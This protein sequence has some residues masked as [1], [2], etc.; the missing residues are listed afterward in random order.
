MASSNMRNMPP[1][2]N[3]LVVEPHLASIPTPPPPQKIKV[4]IANVKAVFVPGGGTWGGGSRSFLLD[5]K[6]AAGMAIYSSLHRFK[7]F[8]PQETKF[9]YLCCAII[10]SC[11]K[12]VA[13]VS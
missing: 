8:F 3:V 13:M 11:D 5:V 2:D 1:T 9:T 10:R 4:K 7:H 12:V 6:M